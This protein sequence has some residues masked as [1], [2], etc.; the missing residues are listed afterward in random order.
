[1]GPGPICGVTINIYLYCVWNVLSA[2]YDGFYLSMIYIPWGLRTYF[3]TVVA[4][5]DIEISYSYKMDFHKFIKTYR[6]TFNI[7]L[8]TVV[9]YSW[10]N[11][12]FNHRRYINCKMLFSIVNYTE[13][14]NHNLLKDIFFIMLYNLRIERSLL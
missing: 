6:I 1:M 9:H 12:S 5:C 11:I 2:S 7:N 8:G 10:S 14:N 13:R 3:G 4:W